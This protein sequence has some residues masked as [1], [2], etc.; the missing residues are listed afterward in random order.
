MD[1]APQ[2]DP[3]LT[4]P[5]LSHDDP[6]RRKTDRELERDESS[7]TGHERGQVKDNLR[8]SAITVFSVI[9]RE[10]EEELHRPAMSL[11]W[12]GIAAGIGIS[13][14]IFAQG[15]LHQSF[16]DHPQR[17]LIAAF[18]YAMG[19]VLVVLSRL[20]LFTEN[21]LTAVLPLL[22]GPNAERLWRTARLWAIVLAANLVGTLLTALLMD[23]FVDPAHP[24]LAGMLEVSRKAAE[25]R[26]WPALLD[27]VP[28]GFFIAAFVWMLPSSKGFEIFVVALF[29]WLISAGGFAHVVAGSTE[30]FLLVLHGEMPVLDAFTLHLAPTLVGNVIGGTGLFALLAFAQIKAEI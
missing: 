27:G 21:T 15:L 11:W 4:D 28:A 30:M 5:E 22:A 7:L 25:A 9:R 8:L 10:G 17:A 12:S 26:G 6:S 20:Q 18:G 16:A 1:D 2:T 24:T 19:F 23:L 14:S 29:A 3:D 13:T